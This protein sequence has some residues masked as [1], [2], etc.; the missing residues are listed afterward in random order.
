M[1]TTNILYI[2]C[3]QLRADALGYAGKFPVATPN[4]DRLA[5]RGTRFENAYTP[6]PVCVPARASV[7]TGVN[8]YDHGVYYNDQGWPERLKPFPQTLAENCYYTSLIGKTHFHPKRRSA[9]FQKMVLASDYSDYINRRGLG[10]KKVPGSVSDVEA[11]NRAYPLEPTDTPI[12]HY[13]P[14][15]YTDRAEHELDLITQRRECHAEGHEPFMLH[16]SYSLPHSPCNPPE[17]YFSMYQPEDLIPPAATEAELA[18]FSAQMRSFYDIWHQMDPERLLKT[19]AQYFGCVSLIDDQ[20]GR[21]LDKLDALGLTENT[22]VVLTSDHGDYLCDHHLQQKAG[23]HDASAR[24]PL[25]F[26]GPGVP[27]GKVVR[28]NISLID[29]PA[30]LL[31]YTQLAVT[32]R[33]DAAGNLIYVDAEESDAM[34]LMP[35]FTDDGPVA[36]ERIVISENAMRGQRIMLKQGDL[37]VTCYVNPDAPDEWDVFD[38]AADPDELDNR[39]AGFTADDLAPDMR[40]ALENV[41]A[42]S[43]RHADGHYFFQGK[44]RPMF[45]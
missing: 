17:P 26:A 43:R 44:V 18:H 8:S 38:L 33:R 28:E 4:I 14:V 42:K 19:R 11:L 15:Y 3:D 13:R 30:T 24:V 35:Y 36:P 5:A 40:A 37:K 21:I 10:R 29:L 12:E 16:V 20:V 32:R 45:T 23:M 31:D 27:E 7:M 2:M 9:G 6:N 25:M 1:S 22:L 34:S 39:G 41:L